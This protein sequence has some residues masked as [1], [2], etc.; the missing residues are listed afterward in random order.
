MNEEQARLR[1][2]QLQKKREARLN[3]IKEI[4]PENVPMPASL[5]PFD[6]R[7]IKNIDDFPK[8]EPIIE[9]KFQEKEI[10][11]QI[12]KEEPS[13]EIKISKKPPPFSINKKYFNAYYFVA[14]IIGAFAFPY[15]SLI[16]SF[17]DLIIGGVIPLLYNYLIR[18]CIIGHCV[19]S[20]IVFFVSY[21][22]R[23][24]KYTFIMLIGRVIYEMLNELIEYH[25]KYQ[26]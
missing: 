14:F 6:D 1:R 26:C 5:T 2:E 25:H 20:F 22:T 4:K 23:L 13:Q 15:G 19:T 24:P 9:K 16:I 8:T 21:S 10:I 12:S 17:L 3:R 11:P 7:I 18:G